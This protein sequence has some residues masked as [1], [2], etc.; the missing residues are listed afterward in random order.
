[1]LRELIFALV[2][3]ILLT[4]GCIEFQGAELDNSTEAKVLPFELTFESA[5]LGRTEDGGT[6]FNLKKFI[7]VLTFIHHLRCYI[8]LYIIYVKNS[9]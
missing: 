3:V 1:M 6:L 2:T 5:T 9:S 4:P 7:S 8:L